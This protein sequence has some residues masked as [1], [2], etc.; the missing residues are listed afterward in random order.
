MG[1]IFIIP[2]PRHL[3]ST[4]PGLPRAES[5]LISIFHFP[6]VRPSVRLSDRLSVRLSVWLP[7][8]LSVPSVRPSV[9][10]P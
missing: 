10:L 9:R 7:V 1:H 3:Q 4:S 5:H 6:S 2:R 8:S